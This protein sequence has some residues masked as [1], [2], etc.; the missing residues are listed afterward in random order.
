M[1]AIDAAM[2]S[3]GLAM[4]EEQ[5]RGLVEALEL[6]ALLNDRFDGDIHDIGALRA[7]VSWFK[8]SE[9]RKVAGCYAKRLRRLERTRPAA[10][11]GIP[12]VKCYRENVNH[13]S[14]T[15]LWAVARAGDFA[16]AEQEI[17]HEP[18]LRLLYQI[19]MQ[20]QLMD[21]LF[22][23]RADRSRGLP[24]FATGPEV[25]AV[26]LHELVSVYSDPMC[27]RLDRNFCLRVALKVVGTC[28]RWVISM[29]LA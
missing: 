9:Y 15:F 25:T 1:I 16:S 26:S 6:G 13:V 11:E 2:K 19:V 29:R 14:L 4:R 21:D 7:A 8:K 17:R 22:D 24:S 18:D 5:R 27:I 23:V 28:L 12:A 10:S 3:R 20:C